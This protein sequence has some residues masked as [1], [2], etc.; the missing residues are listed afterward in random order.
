MYYFHIYYFYIFNIFSDCAK[1]DTG[2]GFNIPT[3][4]YGQLRSK[5]GNSL[6]LGMEVMAGIIDRDYK[7]N[8]FVI[9]RNFS[10]EKVIVRKGMRICQIIFMSYI[11][12]TMIETY[13]L[14]QSNRDRKGFGSTG[15]GL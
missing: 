12:S 14:G 4:I 5:S 8:I 11:Q 6:H 15:G 10:D 1:I 9:L 3:G 13:S 2:I 7:G